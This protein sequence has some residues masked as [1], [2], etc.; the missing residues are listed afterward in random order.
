MTGD[1]LTPDD[2]KKIMKNFSGYDISPD[3]VGLS[4]VNM[5]LHNFTSPKVYEYDTLTSE[6]RWGEY[7]RCDTCQ[8]SLYVA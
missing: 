5:Y 2:R 1:M 7:F 3:M 4:L 6:D 8:S